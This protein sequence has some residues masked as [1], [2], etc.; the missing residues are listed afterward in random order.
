MYT[1]I[2]KQLW[3]ESWIWEQTQYALDLSCFECY[4]SLTNEELIRHW[5]LCELVRFA[6][7]HAGRDESN[8]R[9]FMSFH[10]RPKMFYLFYR[11]TL[12]QWFRREGRAQRGAKCAKFKSCSNKYK[13]S[14]EFMFW[15][16]INSSRLPPCK[17]S[18]KT[19]CTLQTGSS[20]FLP[21]NNCVLSYSV[22][23]PFT[24]AHNLPRAAR[25][26]LRRI[27]PFLMDCCRRRARAQRGNVFNIWLAFLF[28]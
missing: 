22:V 13:R 6:I 1:W 7:H 8:I 5:S 20:S 18:F 27:L 9:H 25:K 10:D 2:S 28:A 16:S 15:H 23:L 21:W 17:F 14:H 4:S 26:F 12:S 3:A 11:Q 19:F 24:L